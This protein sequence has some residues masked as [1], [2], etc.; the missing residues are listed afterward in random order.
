MLRKVLLGVLTALAAGM[1][2]YQGCG[3]DG[4]GGDGQQ[5]LSFDSET[6]LPANGGAAMAVAFGTQLAATMP[7]IF[8]AL[9]DETATASS[10]VQRKQLQV[11]LA[12]CDGGTAQIEVDEIPPPAGSVATVTF[13]GCTGSPL[14][15]TAVNGQLVL[16]NISVGPAADAFNP[17][18]ADARFAGLPESVDFEVFTIAGEPNDT[19]LTGVASVTGDFDPSVLAP[20][21]IMM[22]LAAQRKDGGPVTI[23]EGDRQLQL[24]CFD[25]DTTIDIGDKVCDE[26]SDEA[27]DPCVADDDCTNGLCINEA[28]AI[29]VFKP[30]GVLSLFVDVKRA[31]VYT[32]NS[33]AVP[34]SPPVPDIGFPPGSSI[35]NSGSLTLHSGDLIGDEGC[36]AIKGGPFRGDGSTTTATFESEPEGRVTI[37]VQGL[38]CFECET[39]W[40]N[41]LDTLSDIA[42]PD[43]CD[44]VEC[45]GTGGSGGSGGTGGTAGTPTDYLL[46]V[47][48]CTGDG[49]RGFMSFLDT[50][51]GV[52]RYV[53]DVPDHNVYDLPENVTYDEDTR[54]AQWPIDVDGD[55]SA[56]T[57]V[58]TELT[59][60]GDLSN[61][62]GGGEIIHALWGWLTR[63]VGVTGAGKLAIRGLDDNTIQ[64]LPLEEPFYTDR[65]DC[66]FRVTNIGYHLDLATPGSERFAF[67]GV[68]FKILEVPESPESPESPIFEDAWAT[69]TET[70]VE[71]TGCKPSSQPTCEQVSFSLDADTYELVR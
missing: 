58:G 70:T 44:K 1:I 32:L 9:V 55:G 68:G 6:A 63:D 25:I 19:V 37:E 16:S 33:V 71:I 11:E 60:N 4:G 52:L 13:E 12:L 59:S 21:T 29:T 54:Q 15:S 62:I 38:E 56:R 67:A 45:G 27:G 50:L 23:S 42:F 18:S 24:G 40:E 34:P 35:P 53:D 49:L 20:E 22:T 7:T 47:S 30:R 8:Q 57:N 48:E 26:A 17:I 65:V 5:A 39:T 66:W 69:F 2:M 51:D 64:V 31:G 36:P 10:E 43:S 41:L 46:A 28:S 14:S 3:G 61:G